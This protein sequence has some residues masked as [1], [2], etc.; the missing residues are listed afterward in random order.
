MVHIDAVDGCSQ[1]FGGATAINKTILR[2]HMRV[3]QVNEFQCIWVFN[4]A[5]YSDKIKFRRETGS[6]VAVWRRTG[7]VWNEAAF[8]K[9]WPVPAAYC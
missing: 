7:T 3:R 9:D 1:S 6:T 4:H 5:Q 2:G 8:G